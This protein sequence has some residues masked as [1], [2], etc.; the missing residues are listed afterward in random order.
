MNEIDRVL[1][2]SN[3]VTTAVKAV[4]IYCNRAFGCDLY[5]HFE[6]FLSIQLIS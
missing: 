4:C 3:M 2:P 5:P 1:S 6:S